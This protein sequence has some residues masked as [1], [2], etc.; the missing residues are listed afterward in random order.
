MN[1]IIASLVIALA[2]TG[3]TSIPVATEQQIV[4]QAAQLGTA[5]ALISDPQYAPDFAA[6]AQVLNSISN[7]TNVVTA[8]SVESALATGGITNTI[9]S[10]AISDAIN[11]GD[12]FITS[13]NADVVVIKE[14]C[15]WVAAGIN[16][17]LALSSAHILALP[18]KK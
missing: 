11:D 7:S 15:G 10:L 6:G 13:N 5:T 3:C 8:T 12:S 9:V 2:L 17:S 4:T 18:P 14:V 16:Q 1:K